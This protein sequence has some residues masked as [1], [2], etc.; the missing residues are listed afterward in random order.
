MT[1]YSVALAPAFALLSACATLQPASAPSSG[2]DAT[3]AAQQAAIGAPPPVETLD[4]T[5]PPPPP[6][7]ATTADQ[8][9]TTTEEDRA[10]ATAATAGGETQLGTTLATLGNPASPGIWIETPFVT[11]VTAGRVERS[12]GEGIN[13]ELRPSGGQPGSGSEISLPAM[14]L[15]NLPLTAIEELTV[16]S[17]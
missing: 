10:E 1:R 16:Y 6:A 9:D 7:G 13:I 8:F 14:Q 4:L 12:N 5:P 3:A 2:P 15:L 11:S 17:L